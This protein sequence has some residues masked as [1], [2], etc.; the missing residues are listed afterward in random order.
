MYVQDMA[1]VL[2]FAGQKNVESP[3][4]DSPVAQLMGMK[5]VSKGREGTLDYK[6]HWYSRFY[7]I[8]WLKNFRYFLLNLE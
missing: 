1:E 5:Q 8:F 2:S 7:L 6:L 3:V 4:D